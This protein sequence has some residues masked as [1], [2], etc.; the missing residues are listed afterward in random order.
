MESCPGCI[1]TTSGKNALLTRSSC[2][3][4]NRAEAHG[5]EAEVDKEQSIA[6][7]VSL[8]GPAPCSRSLSRRSLRLAS[9]I[10]PQGVPAAALG[11]EVVENKEDGE[12]ALEACAQ[13]CCTQLPHQGSSSPKRETL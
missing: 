11:M 13:I 8:H 4:S 9:E 7:T 12:D 1:A 3:V 5:G 6:A 10:L 2:S